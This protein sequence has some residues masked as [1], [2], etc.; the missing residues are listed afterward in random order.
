MTRLR[1]RERMPPASSSASPTSIGWMGYTAREKIFGILNDVLKSKT[2]QLD[3]F[4]YDLNEPDV[5]DA[6]LKLAAKGRVRLILDNAALH[7]T[8]DNSKP[9]DEFESL[10][11]K[12]KK[13]NAG[14]RARPLQPVCARQSDVRVRLERAA[15]GL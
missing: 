14:L 7:H 15:A 10:F 12:A 4:A 6:L 9:E 11:N 3:M 5:L 13:G 1:T 2:L 8:A